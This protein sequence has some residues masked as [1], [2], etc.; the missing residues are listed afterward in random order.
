LKTVV[1]SCFEKL[2]QTISQELTSVDKL[3]Q[4]KLN[5]NRP[6]MLDGKVPTKK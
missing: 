6:L 5:P 1:I 3:K 4:V 2:S